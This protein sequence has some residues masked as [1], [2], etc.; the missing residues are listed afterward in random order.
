MSG[1]I[2]NYD[3]YQ[4]GDMFRAR[5]QIDSIELSASSNAA[6][7]IQNAISELEGNGGEVAIQRGDFDLDAPLV[8]PDNIWLRGSGRGTRLHVSPGTTHG[9]IC[10]EGKGVVISDLSVLSAQRHAACDGV[11]VTNSGDCQVRNVF[12]QGF[13]EC[14]IVLR[15]NSFLCHL[16]SCKS[17]DN[18]RANILTSSMVN[19]GRGGDYVPNLITNCITYAGGTGIEVEDTIVLNIVGCAVFQPTG[20]GYHVH[21]VSNSVLIS[22]S[23]SF[24]CGRN[25][26]LVDSSHELNLSSNIFCWHRGHGIELQNVSWGSINANEVIDQG[27]RTRDGAFTDG[28]ILSRGTEGLQVVGNTIF[29]WGDQVPMRCGVV[30]DKSCRNNIVSNNNINYFNEKALSLAG[31]ETIVSNNVVAETD[32]YQGMGR[33]ACPD[34]DMARI[35]AFMRI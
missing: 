35:E 4:D 26:V 30:E 29:N 22:G 9:I 21:S 2:Q 25:A 32:A 28:I 5:G 14:G 7:T 1:L 31:D 6:D 17:A 18:G 10:D 23:R 12:T 8:L 19:D 33:Q 15:E 16:D 3:V 24:Q 27:V 20:H 11:V 34:Y 13:S